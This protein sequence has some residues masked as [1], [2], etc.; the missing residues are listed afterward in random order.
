MKRL[1]RAAHRLSDLIGEDHDLAI[2]EQRAEERRDRFD[3]EGT[4][5]QLSALIE[6]R[7][8]ELR[9]E[10]LEVAGHVYRSKPRKVVRPLERS[11]VGS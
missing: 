10:A 9:P 7:R 3:E 11:A 4:V 8:D 2:L 1:S 5:G 6:R